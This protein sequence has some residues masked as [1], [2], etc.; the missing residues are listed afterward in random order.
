[1]NAMIRLIQRPSDRMFSLIIV[2]L[3]FLGYV[4]AVRLPSLGY[5]LRIYSTF[6]TYVNQ[7]GELPI[8]GQFIGVEPIAASYGDFPAMALNIYRVLSLSGAAPN[9]WVWAAYFLIPVV[10]AAWALSKWGFRL[11]LPTSTARATAI[12][13]VAFGSW[14]T[15]GYEDKT[16][17][18]WLFIAAMFAIAANHRFGSL[19]SGVFAGW[20]GLV[21]LAPFM[22]ATRITHNRA[23]RVV[24]FLITTLSAL[25]LAV[26][27]GP[28]SL[29]LLNNRRLRESGDTI[30]WGFWQYLPALDT[31]II[32]FGLTAIL[33]IATFI[34]FQRGWLSF[35]AAFIFMAIAMVSS[36][37]SFGYF[38]FY[39]LLPL[40]VFLFR[41]PP[42]QMFYLTFICVWAI[43]P[44]SDFLRSGSVF[45]DQ[46]LSSSSYSLVVL[47]TNLP[48]LVVLLAW[49]GR[50][51]WARLGEKQTHNS[52]F[53]PNALQGKR[54]L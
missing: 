34:L 29:T 7:T 9:K 14:T 32:R 23:Q 19:A 22:T 4:F 6:G 47:L 31:P 53:Q 1:M 35:P 17:M 39:N 51:P 3:G 40:A 52:I 12:V 37:N 2:V 8:Q 16:Y 33:S 24:L 45:A 46:G 38:R 5:D 20:T 10:I 27:A 15:R 42:M 30:F 18:F 49:L 26:A 13:A 41:T 11:G 43:F 44:Y 48:L 50:V 54:S 21:P 28:M 36:S 25:T